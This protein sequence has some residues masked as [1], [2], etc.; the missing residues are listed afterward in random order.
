MNNIDASTNTE[1]LKGILYII[2]G[3]VLIFYTLGLFSSTLSVFIVLGGIAMIA[4]GV[5][6]SNL[7]ERIRELTKRRSAK[8]AERRETQREAR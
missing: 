6:R 2:G 8:T 4:Y 7:I 3:F 1:M 5:M